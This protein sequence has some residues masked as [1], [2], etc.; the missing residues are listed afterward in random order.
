MKWFNLLKVYKFNQLQ[1]HQEREIDPHDSAVYIKL[2]WSR[3]RNLLLR[4]TSS[5]SQ[6]EQASVCKHIKSCLAI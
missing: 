4:A 3:E 6:S 2:Q 1:R 5:E